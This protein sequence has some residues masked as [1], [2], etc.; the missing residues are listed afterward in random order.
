L[1]NKRNG[2]ATL[3]PRA[4]QAAAI[5][6][7]VLDR[8]FVYVGKVKL[9]KDFVTIESASNIRYWGTTRGLGELVNGPLEKTKLDPVGKVLAPARAL[10][11]L[12]DVNQAAWKSRI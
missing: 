9:S 11:S 10:I 5:K 3:M 7:V 2:G 12:I 1:D 8:G 6:I 4:P